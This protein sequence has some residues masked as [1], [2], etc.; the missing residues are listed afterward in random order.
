MGTSKKGQVERK[1]SL[2]CR[3]E[4]EPTAESERRVW[5]RK[6]NGEKKKKL[7]SEKEIKGAGRNSAASYFSWIRRGI[8][9]SW[10]S[11]IRFR[12]YIGSRAFLVNPLERVPLVYKR[13][14]LYIYVRYVYVSCIYTYMYIDISYIYIPYTYM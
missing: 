4:R 2:S 7:R 8:L 12:V 1:H 3:E 9:R 13:F 10:E 6:K 5:G 11:N 14:L